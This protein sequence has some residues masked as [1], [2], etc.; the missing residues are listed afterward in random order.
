MVPAAV[1]QRNATNNIMETI[2]SVNGLYQQVDCGVWCT[3][4]IRITGMDGPY[5]AV[6]IDGIRFAPRFT[7]DSYRTFHGRTNFDFSVAP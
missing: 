2:Q 1:L 5:T 6:R 4:N 7:I 3:N